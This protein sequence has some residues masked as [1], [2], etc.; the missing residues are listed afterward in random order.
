MSITMQQYGPKGFCDDYLLLGNSVPGAASD[1]KGILYVISMILFLAGFSIAVSSEQRDSTTR[2]LAF[3]RAEWIEIVDE[4][5]IVRAVLGTRPDMGGGL[6]IPNMDQPLASIGTN[7]GGDPMV[8]T[9]K[10]DQELMS[11]LYVMNDSPGI[12]IFNGDGQVIVVSETRSAGMMATR[13]S[14]KELVSLLALGGVGAGV[15]MTDRDGKRFVFSTDN[16]K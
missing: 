5:G 7:R 11:F 3:V 16:A 9:S 4:Q 15:E 2:S 8:A 13:K 14:T 12:T 6:F 10:K 1:N